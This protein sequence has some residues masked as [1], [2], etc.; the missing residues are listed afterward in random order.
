MMLKVI[1]RICE[2]WIVT[3][4]SVNQYILCCNDCHEWLHNS[5]ESPCIF[6]FKLDI[7]KIQSINMHKMF[8]CVLFKIPSLN[9]QIFRT[10]REIRISQYSMY[11]LYKIPI[12]KLFQLHVVMQPYTWFQ[13][14]LW[15]DYSNTL[16]K[17]CVYASS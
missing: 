4:Y 16:A 3:Y 13:S 2:R 11:A 5:K 8:K 7:Y 1:L 6:I 12:Y 9:I 17:F 15:R 14:P 10:I